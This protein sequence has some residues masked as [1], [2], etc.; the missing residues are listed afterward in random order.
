MRRTAN[1]IV[2]TFSAVVTTAILSSALLLN[3]IIKNFT[4][5]DLAI[6]GTYL[7]N[8]FELFGVG[9]RDFGWSPT[10]NSLQPF[11]DEN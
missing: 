11:H 8:P 9:Q 3:M 2:I 5:L 1:V 6:V 10:F 4:M 7:V